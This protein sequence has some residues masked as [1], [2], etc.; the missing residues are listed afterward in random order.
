ML[1]LVQLDWLAGHYPHHLSG[2]QQQRVAL[3]GAL[4]V[5]PKVLL[6]DEPVSRSTRSRGRNC[7]RR[8]AGCRR[9]HITTLFVTHDQEEALEVSDR[10]VVMNAGRIEQFGTP[11]EVYDHPATPFV[12]QFLGDVNLFHG[13]VHEGRAVIGQLAGAGA[14]RFAR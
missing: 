8:C 7:A 9:I 14:G 3:A 10:V 4:A 13:R 2:G 11:D 1:E 5:E 12:Y 6:L